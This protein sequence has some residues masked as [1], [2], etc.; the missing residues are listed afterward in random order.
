MAYTISQPSE[1]DHPTF[2][3][4]ERCP[5][6]PLDHLRFRMRLERDNSTIVFAE[7]YLVS[8]D[9]DVVRADLCAASMGMELK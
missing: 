7:Y 1:F 3:S 4:G 5:I 2:L 6:T 8:G 9:P